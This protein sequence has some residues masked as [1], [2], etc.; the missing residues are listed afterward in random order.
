MSNP[1]RA[2]MPWQSMVSRR[3]A[4]TRGSFCRSDPAAVLRGI[5]ERRLAGGDQRGVELGE[6]LQREEHLAADL[7]ELRHVVRAVVAQPMR[8][9][10]DGP[11]IERDVL[12]DPA[13]AA[14]GRPDQPAL[15]GRSG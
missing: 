5:G 8:D 4:V 10:L 15:L 2:P 9:R 7:D 14:G 6:T 13:V 1:T 11:D 12:P 3:D